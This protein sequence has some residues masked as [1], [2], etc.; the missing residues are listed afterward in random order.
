M[1]IFCLAVATGALAIG[2]GATDAYAGALKVNCTGTTTEP[3]GSVPGAPPCNIATSGSTTTQIDPGP[4]PNGTTTGGNGAIQNPDSTFSGDGAVDHGFGPIFSDFTF[5]PAPDTQTIGAFLG[6][7]GA[8]T[9]GGLTF[10]NPAVAGDLAENAAFQF[11]GTFTFING[12]VIDITTNAGG[13]T[14]PAEPAEILLFV[15]G[16]DVLDTTVGQPTPPNACNDDT[17]GGQNQNTTVIQRTDSTGTN[18]CTYTFT[19]VAGAGTDTYVLDY[20]SG[21]DAPFV[22]A[23][24]NGGLLQD[25]GTVPEPLSLSLFGAALLGMGLVGRRKRT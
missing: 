6:T 3:A 17:A 5:P 22:S 12:F 16:V 14:P 20:Y 23:S 9:N 7:S 4:G 18:F 2:L 8:A 25:A 1:R 10:S 24:V 19:Q 15:N 13:T 11:S 21:I